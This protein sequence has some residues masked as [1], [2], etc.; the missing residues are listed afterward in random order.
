MNQKSPVQ[1]IREIDAEITTLGHAAAVLAW[2]Q[3]TFMPEAAIRDRAEQAALLSKYAH[4]LASSPELGEALAAAGP[5]DKIPDPVDSPLIRKLARDYARATRIPADLVVASRKAAALAQHAWVAARAADDFPAFRPHLE[6]LVAL[7]RQEAAALGFESKPY[8]ALLDAY[9]PGMQSAE[10]ARVFGEMR[11]RLKALLDHIQSRPQVDDSILRHTIEV[12]KQEAF[13]RRLLADLGF[14]SRRGRLDTSAHPFSE[15]LGF[16]DVR[17]TTRWEVDYFPSGI[18]SVVHEAG[19]ALYELGVGQEYRGTSLAAGAS[20]GI[21]ESQSRTWENIVGRSGAFWE[22]YLPELAELHPELSADRSD[23]QDLL[24]AVYRAINKVEPGFIRVE[25]D[26]VTYSLHVMLRFQLELDLIDGRLEVANL[27]EAWGSASQELLGVRP[28]RAAEG[29]LQDVH[30]SAGLFGYFP[31]YAL[32]NIFG[33]QFVKQQEQELGPLAQFIR[34]R[35]FAQILDWQRE[36]I[37]C[38]GSAKTS[39][40]LL[41]DVCGTGLDAEPFLN[42]L[43]TKY[44]AIYA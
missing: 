25:A 3:E 38:W 30:W 35:N 14:D 29:V 34:R 19:H 23:A 22:A 26:E 17:I 43:E 7:K 28:L 31:T 40:E 5:W 42:Y 4:A 2:D 39:T 41:R 11:P 21:H 37:H 36:K 6:D 44:R 8:D 32:G 13:A 33:A 1:K 18:F 10:V 16:D 12:P 24:P 27:P 20:L 9:E 15:R